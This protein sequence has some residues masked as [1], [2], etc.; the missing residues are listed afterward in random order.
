VPAAAVIPWR[1]LNV[2]GIKGSYIFI[3][4]ILFSLFLGE[5]FIGFFVL[6]IFGGYE[7]L[8]LD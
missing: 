3:V 8:F 5:I 4:M 2:F 7:I 6:Y 1:R